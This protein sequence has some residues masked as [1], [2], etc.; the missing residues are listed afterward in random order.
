M[1]PMQIFLSY[2]S[3]DVKKVS[4]LYKRLIKDG[5]SVWFDRESIIPGQDWQAE[6]RRAVKLSDVAIVCFSEK[7][8]TKEGYVQKEIRMALDVASE[9]PDNAIYLI[10]IKFEDCPIPETLTRL[11]WVNLFEKNGYEKLLR[12]L[13]YCAE[14]KES[15]KEI[16]KKDAV[17]NHI[18]YSN[19]KETKQY[20][21]G[22][23]LNPEN[24]YDLRHAI[25]NGLSPFGYTPYYAD[26]NIVEVQQIL[27][28]ICKKIY[29]T[30]FGIFDIST[31]NPNVYMEIGIA[32]SLNKDFIL[33]ARE[34]SKIP[35]MFD[36]LDIIFYETYSSLEKKLGGIFRNELL[37]QSPNLTRNFC[38]LCRKPCDG[39]ISGIRQKSYVFLNKPTVL[40]QD[41]SNK[42]T[43]IFVKRNLEPVFLAKNDLKLSLRCNVRNKIES[44]KFAVIH[45]GDTYSDETSYFALGLVIGLRK[46][47]LIIKKKADTVSIPSNLEGFARIEYDAQVQLESIEENLK[48]FIDEI[49]PASI[50]IKVNNTRLIS[51]SFG[52]LFQDW[53]EE[54][55]NQFHESR[56]IDGNI[57][58]LMLQDNNTVIQKIPLLKSETIIGRNV[59]VCDIVIDHPGISS[60]HVVIKRTKSGKWTIADLD[61][62]NGTKL[63]GEQIDP[64]KRKRFYLGDTVRLS[65]AKFMI[66]DNSPLPMQPRTIKGTARFDLIPLNLRD[67]LPPEDETSKNREMILAVRVYS[68]GKN[69]S[70]DVQNYYPFRNILKAISE[71]LR[72]LEQLPIDPNDCVFVK[73][74]KTISNDA[75]PASINLRDGELITLY[76][77]LEFIEQIVREL[78]LKIDHN[79]DKSFDLEIVLGQKKIGLFIFKKWSRDDLRYCLKVSQE[80]L[81][82][83]YKTIIVVTNETVLN[84]IKSEQINGAVPIVKLSELPAMIRNV[85][86]S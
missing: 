71:N 5:H 36:G 37:K 84:K 13:Q 29:S 83:G 24:I 78:D 49:D 45:L 32:S 80:E 68:N 34:N 75:T 35:K 61:S 17:Q 47:W 50:D 58:L 62:I 48:G 23:A 55:E 41:I 39:L 25:Q 31:K 81:I 22:H 27:F 51:S 20:F 60:R 72:S 30:D 52:V 43:P 76:T 70:F 53:I 64:G 16:G 74:H 57:F 14:R 8:I 59:E 19:N 28:T 18:Q 73:D 77:F 69:Y 26:R 66:W 2:A 12:A 21:V 33:I 4:S 40:W 7:T 54:F 42:L 46:P 85:I 56:E 11:Q 1:R 3:E 6:I 86:L 15:K 10:P 82:F 67:V 9:K 65:S 79:P 63:N 44:S 38:T